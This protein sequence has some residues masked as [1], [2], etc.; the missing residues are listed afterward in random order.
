MRNDVA[1]EP[2]VARGNSGEHTDSLT[3]KPAANEHASSQ[4]IGVIEGHGLAKAVLN[5]EFQILN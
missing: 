3:P 4:W 5:F 1:S 2:G